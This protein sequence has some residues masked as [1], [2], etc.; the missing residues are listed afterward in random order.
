MTEHQF[1]TLTRA[2]AC[3]TPKDRRIA[4]LALSES[5]TDVLVALAIELMRANERE[6]RDLAR[7]DA[8]FHLDQAQ[9][10][11]AEW[12]A[13]ID[14]LIATGPGNATDEDVAELFQA[15][16]T[17]LAADVEHQAAEGRLVELQNR[18]RATPDTNDAA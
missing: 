11:G 8:D 6:E 1:P 9:Q 3:M 2:I 16:D 12:L 14:H 13:R 5:S 4:A 18:P 10:A 17:A 7:Y 15:G